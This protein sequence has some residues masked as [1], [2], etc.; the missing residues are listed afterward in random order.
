MCFGMTK[1]VLACSAVIVSQQEILLFAKKESRLVSVCFCLFKRLGI[2]NRYRKSNDS[3]SNATHLQ[4]AQAEPAKHVFTLLAHHL[5]ASS[6]ALDKDAASRALLDELVQRVGRPDSAQQ[7]TQAFIFARTLARQRS[8]V[9]TPTVQTERQVAALAVH[10]QSAIA[11]Q[12]E[13]AVELAVEIG[14]FAQICRGH[15]ADRFAVRSRTPHSI[16]V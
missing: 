16:R 7:K 10:R 3:R 9:G 15:R 13:L 5:S 14:A 4:A 2:P 11:G 8:V 1:L 6:V 12:V